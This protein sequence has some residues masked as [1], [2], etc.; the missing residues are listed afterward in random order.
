MSSMLPRNDQH[1]ALLTSLSEQPFALGVCTDLSV[2]PGP[3]MLPSTA[4]IRI[5]WI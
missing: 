3:F 1:I 5:A 2:F 4:H